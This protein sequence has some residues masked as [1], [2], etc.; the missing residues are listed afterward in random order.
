MSLRTDPI[1]GMWLISFWILGLIAIGAAITT[2]LI[3]AGVHI[4]RALTTL[5]KAEADA[6]TNPIMGALTTLAGALFLKDLRQGS[7]DTWPSE[8][9]RKEVARAF[10]DVFVADTPP[11]EA[12]YE[13]HVHATLDT[14][15]IQ[16]WALRSRLRR[17]KIIRDAL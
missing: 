1:G 11:Y 5:S 6:L 16:G 3:F 15:E 2:L 13:D 10:K 14:P 7:G 12:V 9:T 8:I 4:A 17:G